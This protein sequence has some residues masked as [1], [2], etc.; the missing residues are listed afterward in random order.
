MII[1]QLESSK[2]ELAGDSVR[3]DTVNRW[4]KIEET[5][6]GCAKQTNTMMYYLSDV[7]WDISRKL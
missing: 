3:V 5:R 4:E 1:L 2:Q 6:I 7:T